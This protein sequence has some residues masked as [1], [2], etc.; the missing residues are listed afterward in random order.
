[1]AKDAD[2]NYYYDEGTIAEQFEDWDVY[3]DSDGNVGF[4]DGSGEIRL[5]NLGFVL[6]TSR[7]DPE[8]DELADGESMLYIASADSDATEGA[9]VVASGGASS[10]TINEVTTTDVTE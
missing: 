1:M 7:D 3:Q 2:D 4:Y 6:G 8:T 10:V 9:L 5:H